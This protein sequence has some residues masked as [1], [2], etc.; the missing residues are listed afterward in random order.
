MHVR[1]TINQIRLVLLCATALVLAACSSGSGTSMLALEDE[2]AEMRAAI[3]QKIGTTPLEVQQA[4]DTTPEQQQKIAAA[5]TERVKLRHGVSSDVAMQRHL[6]SVADNLAASSGSRPKSFRVILLKS[7]QANA[8]TPGAGTILINEGLLQ[9]ANSEAEV[10]AVMAHEMAHVLMNHPQRQKQIRL[11]SK[12]GGKMMDRFTPTRLQDNI[13]RFLRLS[14]NATLNG[15]IRQQEMMADSIA[16]DMLVK[17]GYD[18]RAMVKV[19]YTLRGNAP[20][21][22]R[23]TNV[24]FGN[25]PLTIDREKAAI[26]KIDARFQAVSGTTS[27]LRFDTLARPYLLKRQKRIAQRG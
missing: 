2:K 5:V 3:A 24:V 18:P 13:G 23:L 15:M 11:A 16:I 7:N 20:Q 6:Q 19:L 25:H 1:P 12:A 26:E 8:Y 9:L 10:A 17:A 27:T 4:L 22:D 21:K 14:G